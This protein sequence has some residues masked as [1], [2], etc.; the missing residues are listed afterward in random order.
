MID[1][2]KT[3]LANRARLATGALMQAQEIICQLGQAY[4]DQIPP[5][6]NHDIEQ[7]FQR[8]QEFIAGIG[9]EAEIAAEESLIPFFIQGEG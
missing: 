9:D 5:D 7:A 4:P 2:D 3:Y 1:R 6:L 8:I